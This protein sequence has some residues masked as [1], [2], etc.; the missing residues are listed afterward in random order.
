MKS[1]KNTYGNGIFRRF[2]RSKLSYW[3]KHLESKK[4]KKVILSNIF[5]QD[6]FF[7]CNGIKDFLSK[8]RVGTFYS[9]L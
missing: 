4:Y 3:L 8:E 5:R 6:N 7:M 1:P 9:N 2:T